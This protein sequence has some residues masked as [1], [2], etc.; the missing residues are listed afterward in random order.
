MHDA[1][2]D[3]WRHSYEPRHNF[4]F[5]QAPAPAPAREPAAAASTPEARH[6]TAR[7][8]LLDHGYPQSRNFLRTCTA[9]AVAAVSI[10]EAR[11]MTVHDELRHHSHP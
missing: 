6:M 8:E 7:E 11:H 3:G 9:A 4:C 2:Y 10:P 1:S 5:L